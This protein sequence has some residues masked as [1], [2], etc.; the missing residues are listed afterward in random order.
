MLL[1]KQSLIVANMWRLS[2]CTKTQTM[3]PRHWKECAQDCGYSEESG[4]ITKLSHGENTWLV[5]R[6]SLFAPPDST[7]GRSLGA[8]LR[9]LAWFGRLARLV[10]WLSMNVGSKNIKF[11]TRHRLIKANICSRLGAFGVFGSDSRLW[12]QRLL[13]MGGFAPGGI[14][15]RLGFLPLAS[16]VIVPDPLGTWF[17]GLGRFTF[18]LSYIGFAVW[19]GRAARLQR[20]IALASLV[21]TVALLGI[22]L[23]LFL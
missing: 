19:L 20:S 6:R 4:I 18:L 10:F 17:V 15:C 14:T 1:Q 3:T 16:H 11:G 23:E 12:G 9:G 13:R 21:G 22:T 5:L 7:F 8:S 2:P